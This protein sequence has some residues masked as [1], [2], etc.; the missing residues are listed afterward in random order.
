MSAS[1]RALSLLRIRR[2]VTKELRQLFRD[3]KTKRVIF[4]A[5]VLQLI[6][7]GYAVNTNVYDVA[8]ALVD[9]DNTAESRA[10]VESLTASGY[11]RVVLS[12]DRSADL[13]EALDRGQARVAFQIPAGY[14]ADLKAGRGP[15]V[16][17]LVD[18]TNSNTATVAQGYAA[19][20]IQQRGAR[21]AL[22]SGRALPQGV[23]LRSPGLVQPR[24]RQSGVQRACRHRRDR[25][26]HVP[27]PHCPLRRTRA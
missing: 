27:T 5:P 15:V 23:E 2:L 6:L 4:G 26:P 3:P 12:S 1:T 10:L 22:E 24:P 21:A 13:G 7:F 14:S 17:L 8:T 19:K 16:Q 25:A 20:I 18:G 9:H 11:F